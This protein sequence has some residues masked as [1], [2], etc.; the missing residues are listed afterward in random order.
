M[1]GVNTARRTHA[2]ACTCHARNQAA[3][4]PDGMTL[5]LVRHDI[6]LDRRRLR[7]AAMS[8]SAVAYTC[9]NATHLCLHPST[10]VHT[11]LSGVDEPL[12]VALQALVEV[13]E[14][15]RSTREYDILDAR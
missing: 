1:R 15:R 8:S 13:L 11:R 5:T 9:P 10:R 14:H 3:A 4:K 6:H 12:D 7:S 2:L